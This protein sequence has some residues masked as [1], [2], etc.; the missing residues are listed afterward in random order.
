MTISLAVLL[1]TAPR[2]DFGNIMS[3]SAGG[4]ASIH[5]YRHSYE[6]IKKAQCFWVDVS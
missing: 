3:L 4:S 6:R 2:E 1:L 5:T